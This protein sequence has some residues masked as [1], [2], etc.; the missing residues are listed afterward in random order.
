MYFVYRD[1]IYHDVAGKSFRDFMAG[2]LEGFE[3]ELPHMGDWADHMTTN[4]PEVRLKKYIEMRGTDGGPWKNLVLCQHFGLDCC[5]TLTHSRQRGTSLKTGPMLKR[6]HEKA[7]SGRG[8][9]TKFRNTTLQQLA[10]QVLLYL[11]EV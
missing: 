1:G 6:R 11:L 8:L 5:M 4:F 7:S 10:K 9:S 2:K 3:G